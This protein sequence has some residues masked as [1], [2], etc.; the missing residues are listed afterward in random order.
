MR[1][2]PIPLLMISF[3]S[4]IL[5]IP[6]ALCAQTIKLNAGTSFS[7]V[8][9]NPDLHPTGIKNVAIGFSGTIG[10][11]FVERKWGFLSANIG[12]VQ[13]GR[14]DRVTYTDVNGNSSYDKTNV[15]R[16]TYLTANATVNFKL[17][18][19]SLVPFLGIGPRLDYLLN[20]SS[21]IDP[22]RLELAYGVIGGFGLMKKFDKIQIGGRVDYLYSIK[23]EPID[24][25]GTVMIFAG[26]GI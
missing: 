26:W 19:S 14:K 12:I 10:A 2:L 16:F 6:A 9:S 21:F 8:N 3:S 24:R 23:K 11:D 18:Q 22:E 20:K 15:I 7:V 17:S 25:T 5:L 4:F 1:K 13:K